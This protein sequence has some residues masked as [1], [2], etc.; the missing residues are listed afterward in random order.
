M[1]ERLE[2]MK[3]ER[4]IIVEEESQLP[5]DLVQSLPQA[6]E[7]STNVKSL[8]DPDLQGSQQTILQKS[9]SQTILANDRIDVGQGNQVDVGDLQ[10]TQS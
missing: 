10:A 6:H 7:S 1:N 8:G 5:N 2:V 4:K 9:A 3:E